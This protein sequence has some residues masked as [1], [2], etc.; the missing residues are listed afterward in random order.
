MLLIKE[1]VLTTE[2][3]FKLIKKIGKQVDKDIELVAYIPKAGYRFGKALANYI[4]RPL[5]NA[6]ELEDL[7]KKVLLVDCICDTGKT[8]EKYTKKL[9]PIQTA[10][11]VNRKKKDKLIKPDIVGLEYSKSYFL[12]GYGLDYND[13]WRQLPFISGGI[14]TDGESF[15]TRRKEQ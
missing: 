4:E 9:K 3:I 14:L 8:L 6:D 1:I 15:Y 13:K 5:V 10:V 7:N 2:Q 12:V 11:L